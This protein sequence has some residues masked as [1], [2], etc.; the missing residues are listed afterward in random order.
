MKTFLIAALTADGFIARSSDHLADWTSKEDKVF[1]TKRTKQ[2]GVVVMG[3]N[4]YKTIGRPLG[5]R[6]NVVYAPATERLIGV[7][8]TQREP[9]DLLRH[10][11]S[12]GYK[13]VAIIGGSTIYTLFMKAGLIDTVYLTVEPLFFGEG[14]T[15]FADSLDARLKLRKVKKMREDAI[16]LEY[17]VKKETND[18]RD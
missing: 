3:L 8:L 12:R 10:L 7:E 4:T 13:E 11:E 2:A 17:Q 18:T 6:L 1:F 9:A 15:L 14:L 16:L 5:G